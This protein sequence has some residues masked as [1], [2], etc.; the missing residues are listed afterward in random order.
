MLS[1]GFNSSLMEN[2]LDPNIIKKGIEEIKE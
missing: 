2:Y 1:G